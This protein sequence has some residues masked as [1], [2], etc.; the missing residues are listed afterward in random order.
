MGK[1]TM[2]LTSILSTSSHILV[3]KLNTVNVNHKKESKMTLKNKFN[4]V[5]KFL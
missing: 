2:T 1:C 5:E 3:L 4:G